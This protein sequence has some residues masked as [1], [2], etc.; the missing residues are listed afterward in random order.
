VSSFFLLWRDGTS[1]NREEFLFCFVVRTAMRCGLMWS[2]TDMRIAYATFQPC[3]LSSPLN[4]RS[5]KTNNYRKSL[6]RLPARWRSGSRLGLD[7]VFCSECFLL[8]SSAP[9]YNTRTIFN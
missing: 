1:F 4:R 7:L 5:H 2:R 6:R 8:F 9:P 3:S